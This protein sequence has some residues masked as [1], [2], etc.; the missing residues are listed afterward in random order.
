MEAL[1]VLKRRL[2]AVVFRA[3]VVDRSLTL[4]DAAA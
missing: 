3:M 4:I 2:S 1:R